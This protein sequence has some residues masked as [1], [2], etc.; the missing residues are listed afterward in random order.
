MRVFW[1]VIGMS[2][3]GLSGSNLAFANCGHAKKSYPEKSSVC[4]N[5]SEFVCG[6]LGAWHRTGASC[7]VSAA[8][9]LAPK[10]PPP[11]KKGA[12]DKEKSRAESSTRSE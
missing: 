11:E 5:G 7:E 2:V 10:L 6:E 9:Q 3:I 1:A 4:Q 12:A 8:G